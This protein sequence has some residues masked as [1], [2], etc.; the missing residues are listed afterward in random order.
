METQKKV[1]LITG[2]N[3]YLGRNLALFFKDKYEV[4]LGSRN[5]K[6]NFEATKITGC[7]SVPLDIDNI[8]SVRD[9]VNEFKPSIIVHAAATKFVDL[10]EKFPMECVDVN[11]LGSQNIAR[12][13]FDKGVE[14]VL[15]ISTDKASPPIRNTYGMT[16]AIMERVFCSMNGKGVTKFACV[17]YGNVVW[18]TG[19]VFPLWN[20]MWEKTKVIGTTGP[21]MRRFFFTVNEAVALVNTALENI[22]DIQG[23]VL[24][25]AMKSA[26]VEDILKVWIKNK[27][28]K[29]EKIEGR[30]GERN[31]EFLVGDIELPYTFET[32]Y[33]G[34]KHFVIAFNQKAEKP[35]DH[36]YDSSNAE[37]L[38]E[39]EILGL[40]NGKPTY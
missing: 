13:A 30:P 21:E 2:G 32:M 26:M 35:L 24:S 1:M 5:N 16:K 37:R 33:N 23:K 40:I 34:I 7:K 15:G 10:A 22:N 39:D 29:Y 14:V 18:S 20:D 3:G 27:G 11:V 8:E 38:N 17:R 6:N 25:R 36:V 28:G 19:S 9:V 12:V 31:D 4:I